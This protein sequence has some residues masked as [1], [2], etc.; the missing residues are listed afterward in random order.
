MS[1]T[2]EH[3]VMLYK[4]NITFDG[5]LHSTTTNIASNISNLN[6]FAVALL[7]S[8]YGLQFFNTTLKKQKKNKNVTK[9]IT[10]KTIIQRSSVLCSF[11]CCVGEF[12]IWPSNVKLRHGYRKHIKSTVYYTTIYK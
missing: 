6:L 1:V 10:E 4:M 9:K 8:Q 7:R 2:L 11:T 12:V 3:C 5:V